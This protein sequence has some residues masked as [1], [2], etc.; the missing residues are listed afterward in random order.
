MNLTY[1]K[2]ADGSW[3]V[4]GAGGLSA[5]T[6]VTVRTRA[7]ELKTEVLAAQVGS[8]T[9]SILPRRMDPRNDPRLYPR[10]RSAGKYKCERCGS[11]TDDLT[12]A[13]CPDCEFVIYG[14]DA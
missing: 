6:E 4:R 1:T 13:L 11:R 2:L 9:Y 10:Y 14:H 7:G 3:G 5:G 12:D 8:G